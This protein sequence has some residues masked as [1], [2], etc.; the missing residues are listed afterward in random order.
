MHT[1]QCLFARSGR[2]SR[3]TVTPT[4]IGVI[5]RITRQLQKRR[6]DRLAGA[7]G[8]GV[9]LVIDL[10]AGKP[11]AQNGKALLMLEALW[12]KVMISKPPSDRWASRLRNS[13]DAW[14]VAGKLALMVTVF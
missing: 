6:Q 11:K 4:D 12:C 10:E 2:M 14:S 7:A 8:I 1:D 5:V 9:R 13:A 3:R